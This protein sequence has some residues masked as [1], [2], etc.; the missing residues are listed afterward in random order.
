MAD[1]GLYFYHPQDSDFPFIDVDFEFSYT[2]L[3][4]TIDSD[5]ILEVAESIAMIMT[6]YTFLSTPKLH[7]DRKQNKILLIGDLD[8]KQRKAW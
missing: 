7:H 4:V 1:D 8:K 6:L 3:Q 2:R 5:N